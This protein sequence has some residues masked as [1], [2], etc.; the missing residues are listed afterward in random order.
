THFHHF[1]RFPLGSALEWREIIAKPSTT[2]ACDGH[3]RTGCHKR[4]RKGKRCRGL[5]GSPQLPTIF[6]NLVETTNRGR[7]VRRGSPAPPQPWNEGFPPLPEAR[8][9]L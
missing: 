5:T 1:L 7:A 3:A 8:A 6:D 4:N 2:I 9:G